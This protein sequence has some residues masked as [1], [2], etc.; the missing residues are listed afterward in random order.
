MYDTQTDEVE[1]YKKQIYA[2]VQSNE[3][4]NKENLQQNKKILLLKSSLDEH[5]SKL[6]QIMNENNT[7]QDQ[8]TFLKTIEEQFIQTTNDKKLLKASLLAKDQ[9]ISDLEQDKQK[10]Q[11]LK[12][13]FE[14]DTTK[15]RKTII[16][17]KEEISGIQGEA[18]SLYDENQ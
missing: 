14:K 11:Q 15:M 2:M 9:A 1:N 7:A 8:L 17:L 16:A 12:K 18:E 5:V 6:G 10:L 3:H 4:L 13:E